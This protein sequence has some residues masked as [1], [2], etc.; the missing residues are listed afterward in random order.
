MVRPVEVKARPEFRIWLKYSNGFA[1]EVDL[2]HLVGRGVFAAWNDESVFLDVR[3][4][5]YGSVAWRNDIELCPD[6][7]FLQL[8]SRPNADPV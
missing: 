8:T 4:T 2:S 1:G 7:L 6:A 5:P 3:I